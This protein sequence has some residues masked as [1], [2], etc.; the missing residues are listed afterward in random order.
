M[1]T[2]IIFT[3]FQIKIYYFKSTKFVFKLHNYILMHFIQVTIMI[4]H[5]NII[6]VRHLN[7]FLTPEFKIV[8]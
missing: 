5:Y 1:H 3:K 7:Y 8:L 2:F 4:I 6:F